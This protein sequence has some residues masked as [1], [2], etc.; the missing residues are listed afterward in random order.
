[1]NFRIPKNIGLRMVVILL[2]C[3]F[4]GFQD[5]FLLKNIIQIAFILITGI[6]ILKTKNLLKAMQGYYGWAIIWCCICLFSA[7]WTV[8]PDGTRAYTISVI[9]N[10]IIG[11]LFVN[12]ISREDNLEWVENAII[13]GAIIMVARVLAS[14]PISVLGTERFGERI[15]L[16]P[17]SA[18][19]NLLYA[20]LISFA[21]YLKEKENKLPY[22][23]ISLIFFVFNICT[24]SKKGLIIG[25][26]VPIALWLIYNRQFKKKIV[27]LVKILGIAFVVIFALAQVPNISN[28]MVRRMD[29]FTEFMSGASAIDE[30][31]AG[32]IEL[33]RQSLS[34]FLENPILGVGLDGFREANS[35]YM[36]GFYAHCNYT[37][38]LADL[39]LV[40]FSIYYIIYAMILKKLFYAFRLGDRSSLCMM[41]IIVTIL[42]QD[43]AQVSYYNEMTQLIIAYVYVYAVKMKQQSKKVNCNGEQ[44]INSCDSGI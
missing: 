11:I 10:V 42:L 19:I 7:L 22:L 31:T 9:Q 12:S 38:L 20:E 35:G 14:T 24:A 16:H 18:S 17:N 37:E 25:L 29:M 13:I 5:Q 28:E 36:H 26:L 4:F 39:G 23:V 2:F 3:S 44:D 33:Y 34:I 40:G 30:S 8:N 43:I 21:R 15:N 32:R 41:A 1:M 27:N 6:E